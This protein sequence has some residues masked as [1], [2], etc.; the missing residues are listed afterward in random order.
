MIA[1]TPA[2]APGR[3]CDSTDMPL[4]WFP[5]RLGAAQVG[6]KEYAG[7]P[8]AGTPGNTSA[9][10]SGKNNVIAAWRELRDRAPVRCKLLLTV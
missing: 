1:A 7:D 8:A 4:I 2:T 9:G 6:F 3:R 5:L 10:P